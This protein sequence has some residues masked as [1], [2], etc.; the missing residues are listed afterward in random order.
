ML[1]RTELV[2]DVISDVV[3]PWC[4]I[5]MKRLEHA[6]NLVEDVEI[7]PRWRPYQLD[8]NIP[9]GGLP[10]K[11]YML[12]KFGSEDRINQMHER[13]S[14]LGEVEGI[15]FNFDAIQ[16]SPNTLDA[17]RLIRWA[18]SPKAPAGAQRLMVKRLFELYFEEGRDIGD[19]NVLIEAADECGLDA[20]L[21]TALLPS[22]A[23]EESLR[24]EIASASA[25]GITGVPSFVFESRY[26]VV[27]AQVSEMLA[28]A[29][30]QIGAAKARGELAKDF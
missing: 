28:D 6:A 18:G 9:K 26:V 19:H 30:R 8:G 20:A 7:K 16:V 1:E 22:P 15:R 2:I 17:H 25:M 29:I 10:R 13:I 11:K 12:D 27:G 4:F 24:A 3:C 14:Q 5:G 23:D 21:V